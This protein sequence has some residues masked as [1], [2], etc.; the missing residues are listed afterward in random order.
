VESD[1]ALSKFIVSGVSFTLPGRLV[2]VIGRADGDVRT[3][4][5]LVDE[6]DLRDL[7]TVA[8]LV[9]Y[10]REFETISSGMTCEIHLAPAVGAEPFRV[11]STPWVRPKRP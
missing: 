6:L 11:P 8:K 9:A 3:G 4:D 2:C 7:G 10:R 5:S 1:A